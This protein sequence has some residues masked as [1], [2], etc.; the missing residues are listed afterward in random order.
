MLTLHISNG[1]RVREQISLPMPLEETASSSPMLTVLSPA[2]AG[3][4]NIL[5]WTMSPHFK[6]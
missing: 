6:S 2:L 4:S 1:T 3:I 5:S